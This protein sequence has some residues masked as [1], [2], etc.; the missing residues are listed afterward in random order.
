M[1]KEE[2]IAKIDSLKRKIKTPGRAYSKSQRE[3]MKEEISYLSKVLRGINFQED[4]ILISEFESNNPDLFVAEKDNLKIQINTIQETLD[5]NVKRII[6]LKINTFLNSIGLIESSQNETMFLKEALSYLDKNEKIPFSNTNSSKNKEELQKKLAIYYKSLTSRIIKLRTTL[7]EI[8]SIKRFFDE[9]SQLKG[10]VFMTKPI[11][12]DASNFDKG[13]A[14]VVKNKTPMYFSFNGNTYHS[15]TIENEIP[16]IEK[17]RLNPDLIP[18]QVNED[19][20][21]TLFGYKNSKN[22]I[23]IPAIFKSASS[24]INGF[25]KVGIQKKEWEKYKNTKITYGLIDLK[26]RIVLPCDFIELGDVY[27]DIILYKKHVHKHQYV[28]ISSFNDN[29]QPD[30]K[31]LGFFSG[32][33]VYNEIKPAILKEIDQMNE[34]ESSISTLKTHGE[35]DNALELIKEHREKIDFYLTYIIE[36]Q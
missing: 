19:T 28:P 30:V 12:S 5:D 23:V 35:V 8:I 11:F 33:L 10:F 16:K 7:A 34:I 18:C 2:L 17:Y 32:Y 24:F 31:H 21:N 20:F 29:V 3:D 15:D 6:E 9:D 27:N 22:E 14:T 13:F 4:L 25:A 1:N 36:N 26:G